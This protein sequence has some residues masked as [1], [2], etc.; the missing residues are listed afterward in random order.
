MAVDF[1]PTDKNIQR[2][3]R[4]AFDYLQNKSN[5]PINIIGSGATVELIKAIAI[6]ICNELG[7]YNETIPSPSTTGSILFDLTTSST[8][9]AIPFDL[10]F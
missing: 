2:I 5:S 3:V 4:D 1:V 10:D 8:K 7:N 6:A 9:E